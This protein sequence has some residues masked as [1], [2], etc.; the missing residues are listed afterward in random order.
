MKQFLQRLLQRP[1]P[2]A[3]AHAP[4][5]GL[6]TAAAVP[7]VWAAG[8]DLPIPDWDATERAHAPGGDRPED[9][10]Q[11]FWT[12]ALRGWAERLR[13]ALGGE[14]RLHE[15]AHFV[16]LSPQDERT[17][18][19]MLD[20][21]EKT[22]QRIH[23]VLPGLSRGDAGRG[24]IGLF[25]F[26]SHDAYYAYVSHYYPQSGE[27]GF[28]S[29]MFIQAGYGHFVFVAEDMLAM[30]PVIA[31]ELTHCQLSHLPLPAWLNEGIAVNTE[32]R[33]APRAHHRPADA[34]QLHRRHLRY[35]NEESIQHFWSGKSFLHADEGQEL[36][37][38]LAAHLVRLA[39][40]DYEPFA[41]FV[42]DAVADDAGDAACRANLGLS[43]VQLAESVLSAG[44]WTPLPARWTDG[45]E[46]GQFRPAP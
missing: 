9:E 18:R 27:F 39:A 38:D 34:A 41:R 10:R 43:L 12:G 44:P 35:W 29:G 45:V 13:E 4:P 5:G 6:L 22:L 20:Y 8:A 37:Y 19:A 28:S 36:S 14:H 40:A 1:T 32:R 2:P 7:L 25:V 17:A 46:A 31:H 11:A 24:K 21:A 16:A 42:R 23:R 30:E 15:S 26:D 3:P 33:L